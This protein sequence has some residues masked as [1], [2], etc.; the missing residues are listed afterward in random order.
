MSG[1]PDLGR[2]FSKLGKSRVWCAVG[3]VAGKVAL[4][5]ITL[6]SVAGL[7]VLLP[8]PLLFA[9]SPADAKM[10]ARLVSVHKR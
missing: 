9:N 6:A 8:S 5:R 10:G 1:L 3:G 2:L 7:A 4:W